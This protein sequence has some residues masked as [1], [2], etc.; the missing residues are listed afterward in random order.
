MRCPVRGTE[1][2]SP[3]RAVPESW[4]AKQ[5]VLTGQELVVCYGFLARPQ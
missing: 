2:P 1:S 5:T 3:A 4:P